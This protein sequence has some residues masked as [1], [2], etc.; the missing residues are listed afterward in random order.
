MAGGIDAP[1]KAIKAADAYA[2]GYG[3]AGQ[4]CRQELPARHHTVLALG[5]PSNHDIRTLVTFDVYRT[6]KV[7]SVGHVGHPSPISCGAAPLC[8]SLSSATIERSLLEKRPANWS[9]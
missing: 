7:I 3:L 1:V 5:E 2:V 4:P 6:F 9:D 8:W